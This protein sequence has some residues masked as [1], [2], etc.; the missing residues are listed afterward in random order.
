MKNTTNGN[1]NNAK[2]SL[3][4]LTKYSLIGF[5]LIKFL[6]LIVESRQGG[7][8]ISLVFQAIEVISWHGTSFFSAITAIAGLKYIFGQKFPL[9][10][11]VIFAI[12]IN[13]VVEG[14][15]MILFDLQG[16]D[17]NDFAAFII[18]LITGILLI[19]R[20]Y[21]QVPN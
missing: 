19:R 5:Y 7:S 1:L 14:F 8:S 2:Q 12:T 10:L 20:I 3:F 15:F 16:W 11:L 18:G 13:I 21:K 4:N 9:V 6:Q 17:Y